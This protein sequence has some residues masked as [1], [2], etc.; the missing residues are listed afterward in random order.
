LADRRP[1][2]LIPIIRE[3]SAGELLGIAEAVLRGEN[4]S[5]QM[6]GVVAH[7]FGRPVAENVTVARRYRALLRRISALQGRR[8]RSLGAQVR[9]ANTVA[10][11]V[12][13]AAYENSTDLIVMDWPD[14]DVTMRASIEDLLESPP[15]DL[16][17]V[18]AAQPDRAAALGVLVPVRGGP[19]AQLALRV[20]AAIATAWQQSLTVLHVR[21]GR[22]SPDRRER[23]SDQFR[24]LVSESGHDCQVVE[25]DSRSP[26]EAIIAEGQK[27]GAVVL[28]AYAEVSR[29]HVVV[30]SR[31]AR[32]VD[33][34]HGYVILAKSPQ[35]LPAISD[36]EAPTPLTLRRPQDISAVV[37]RWFAENTFH[38]REF[39]DVG[40]L[41]ELKRRQGLTISL[42]L[43]TLNEAGTIR[44][45]VT[46]MKTS[47]M[48]R[49]PLLDE[50]VVVDSGSDDGTIDIVRSLGVPVYPHPQ[51]LSELGAFRGKG[52]A[53]WKSLHQV[54]GDIVA[55]CDTD[56]S[57]IHPQFVYGTVGPLLTDPRI[58]YVKGF[59]RRPLQFGGELRTAGG[60]RV[61]ELAARPLL[62][63]FYPELSGLVQPLSGEYAGRREV[64]ERLPFFTGYG[65]EVGH[66]ID[67]LE[68][69]GLN[70][71]AQTDLG[72]RIHRNQELLN[73]SK[74]AFAIMQVAL[75]RL[76]DRH[77][78]HLVEEVNRSMKLIHY[79]NGPFF[80]E[81]VEIADHERPPMASIPE[82]EHSRR[83]LESVAGAEPRPAL[84]AW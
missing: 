57:N 70:T 43:P 12:R 19:S 10:Q 16:V 26:S 8:H 51:I 83:L 15:S 40:R 55:W 67:L 71:I 6:L 80:L 4:G 72:V 35:A 65:V 79:A 11:G 22:H 3:S 58:G 77:R 61:T 17:L 47:L 64:L 5:G 54:R 1:R 68:N 75:K 69:F 31:L 7:P 33:A 62:N 50:I 63:L 41:V 81:V 24:Q 44:E 73:L 21:D 42:A 46:V 84:A 52:E 27:Y 13:E 53:L 28:G 25:V 37:D 49:H 78:M 45:V 20:A 66:L 56:I 59:Y 36:S 34:L 38:S 29:T 9:V 18:R 74:M 48:Q 39:R 2:L 76:G 60:G 82:Y 23:E 32:A 14:A 30:G